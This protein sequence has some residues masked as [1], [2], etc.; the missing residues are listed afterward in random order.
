MWRRPEFIFLCVALVTAAGSMSWF[1][2]NRSSTGRIRPERIKIVSSAPAYLSSVFDVNGAKA[3][4]WQPPSG[5]RKSRQWVYDVFTPPEIFF[6]PHL[7]EFSVTPPTTAIERD[8]STATAAQ[9]P[10]SL[11][12]ELMGV[13]RTLFRL[14][15]I[16]FVES[17]R[18]YQ[19]L[20]E[21]TLTS[22]TFLAA[23][24]RS[25]PALNLVIEDVDVR[26]HSVSLPESMTTQQTLATASV[27]D[28]S[29]GEIIAL[30]TLERCYAAA[31]RATLVTGISAMAQ[32][33]VRN[34]DVIEVDGVTYEIGEIQLAPPSVTICRRAS[35]QVAAERR[36]LNLKDAKAAVTATPST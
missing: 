15:L 8:E 13:K 17:D 4:S 22:E 26:T 16:G 5:Q 24:G 27:R 31:P 35:A 23:K 11:G 14:Q 10:A 32:R 36:T 21:N 12:V 33:D 1:G 28:L 20:F 3:E 25:V 9:R 6:D 2:L 34:G 19:G 30:T 7:K 29:S 18:G